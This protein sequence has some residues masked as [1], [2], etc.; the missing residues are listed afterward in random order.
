MSKKLKLPKMSDVDA[1]YYKNLKADKAYW[2]R[3]A[4]RINIHTFSDMFSISTHNL[5]EWKDPREIGKIWNGTNRGLVSA[6]NEHLQM[7]ALNDFHNVKSITFMMNFM[8]KKRDPF[9]GY[10]E[11]L[12]Y[13]SDGEFRMIQDRRNAIFKEEQGQFK[14]GE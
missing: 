2:M 10:A 3:N 7:K 9:Q 5:F 6:I 8:E 4:E 1:L 12:V 11:T 13:V 14:E